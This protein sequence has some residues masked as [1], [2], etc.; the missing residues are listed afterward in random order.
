MIRFP[1]GG[2]SG[3]VGQQRQR[4]NPRLLLSISLGLVRAVQSTIIGRSSSISTTLNCASALCCSPLLSWFQLIQIRFVFSRSSRR[5]IPLQ[6][7]TINWN[8]WPLLQTT[9]KKVNLFSFFSIFCLCYKIIHLLH[10]LLLL[11]DQLIRLSPSQTIFFS[12]TLSPWL[13]LLA[14]YGDMQIYRE[15]IKKAMT[16]LSFRF[17]TVSKNLCLHLQ[18]SSHR[19][20][21][22]SLSPFRRHPETGGIWNTEINTRAHTKITQHR[23]RK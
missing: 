23:R 20:V 19:I 21:V 22:V 16:R 10:H 14:G 7:L 4:E 6:E 8:P 13:T 11:L 18:H 3:S 15:S 2:Q 9:T 1:L 17:V 5:L 12:R